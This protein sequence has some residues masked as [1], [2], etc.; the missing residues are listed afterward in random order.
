MCSRQESNLCS[1]FRKPKF[2]PLNYESLDY[3]FSRGILSESHL[4]DRSMK[5]TSGSSSCKYLPKISLTLS[6]GWSLSNMI[7]RLGNRNLVSIFKIICPH[8]SV[9]QK[10]L[11]SSHLY[12]FSPVL[13]PL[14]VISCSVFSGS[15]VANP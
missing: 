9:N 1:W 2:Y 3:F 10:R 14:V 13:T 6:W 4:A 5:V 8:L 11:N 12:S 15:T 7:N